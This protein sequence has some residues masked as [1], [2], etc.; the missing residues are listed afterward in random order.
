MIV[1]LL[2][3]TVADVI[4]GAAGFFDEAAKAG[5]IMLNESMTARSKAEITVNFLRIFSYPFLSRVYGPDFGPLAIALNTVFT[6]SRSG[7]FLN[8]VFFFAVNHTADDIKYI[9]YGIKIS[10]CCGRNLT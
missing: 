7:G 6:L 9:M 3:L 1:T 2:P 8:A 4:L 5:W 10:F